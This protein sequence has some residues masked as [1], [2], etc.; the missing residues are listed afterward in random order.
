MRDLQSVSADGV[1]VSSLLTLP[2]SAL[3]CFTP[4]SRVCAANLA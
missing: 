3:T 4:M 1:R 2:P